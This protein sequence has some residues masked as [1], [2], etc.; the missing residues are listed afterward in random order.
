MHNFS[1]GVSNVKD[2]LATQMSISLDHTRSLVH[3]LR[4]VRGSVSNVYLRHSNVC[5]R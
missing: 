2:R 5:A 3:V 4:H 1:S